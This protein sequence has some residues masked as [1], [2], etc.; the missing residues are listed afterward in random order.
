MTGREVEYFLQSLSDI[1]KNHKEWSRDYV[2]NP[3]RNEFDHR[4]FT[5]MKPD[6]LQEWFK[7]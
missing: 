3:K 7:L 5:G 2:Y 1:I 6:W 4:S